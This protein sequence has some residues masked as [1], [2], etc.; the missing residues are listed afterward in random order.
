MWR[1]VGHLAREGDGGRNGFGI[2][3]QEAGF[4]WTTELCQ[5][6]SDCDGK[7]NGEELGD[8]NCIWMP[9]D[10]PESAPTGHARR[11]S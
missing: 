6:D 7:T 11:P 1:G 3:F 2:D 5:M 8:P 9:G 10:S 4:K